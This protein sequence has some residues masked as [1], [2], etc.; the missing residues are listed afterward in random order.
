MPA[1]I[2]LC[3]ERSV[4]VDRVVAE[5]ERLAASGFA[6]IVLAGVH[7]GGYGHDLDPATGFD[8][9]ADVVLS[10]GK[11]EKI[12]KTSKPTG[13]VIDASERAHAERHHG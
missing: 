12:G 10:G 3:L 4:P 5:A 7:L 2:R 8:R 1:M 9:K 13:K 11:V 6:E